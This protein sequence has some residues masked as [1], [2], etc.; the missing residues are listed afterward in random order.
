MKLHSNRTFIYLINYLIIYLFIYSCAGKQYFQHPLLQSSVSHDLS[1]T[2]FIIIN[3][4]N[5][6]AA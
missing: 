2:F 1:V 3:I 5:S 4:E 6:C